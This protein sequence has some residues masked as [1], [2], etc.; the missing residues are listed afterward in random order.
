MFLEKNELNKKDTQEYSVFVYPVTAN[1]LLE[2]QAG[3]VQFFFL[4]HD[5]EILH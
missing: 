4:L 1:H 5:N 3:I 2:L